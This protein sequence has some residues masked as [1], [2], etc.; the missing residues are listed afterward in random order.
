MKPARDLTVASTR[1]IAGQ[2]SARPPRIP[3]MTSKC[4]AILT[5]LLIACSFAARADGATVSLVDGKS[6]AGWE[7]DTNKTWRIAD[8][9]FIGGTL[10]A[11]V[12]Q[13]EFLRTKRS[14]TNFVLR[15]KIKLVGTPA[16]G[17]VNAG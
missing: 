16:S 5:T 13:N 14:Y 1:R 17:F 3:A 9:A 10:T 11:K 6:F 7:G 15:L 12:P 8:G 2:T 4:L